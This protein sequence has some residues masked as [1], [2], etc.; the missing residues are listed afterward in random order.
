MVYAS[1][2]DAVTGVEGVGTVVQ[3][4][5]DCPGDDHVEVDGVGVMH[6]DLPARISTRQ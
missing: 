6:G 1:H 5:L 2:H 4:E 3:D